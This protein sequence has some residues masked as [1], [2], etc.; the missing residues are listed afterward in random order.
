[1]RAGNAFL[2]PVHKLVAE[3]LPEVSSRPEI[4]QDIR[5]AQVFLRV[6]KPLTDCN[7]YKV[8][9]HSPCRLQ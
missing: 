8:F 9:L 4:P 3:I 2:P 6:E 7:A 5:P 1:M